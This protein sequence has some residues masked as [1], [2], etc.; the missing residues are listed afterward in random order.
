MNS[1]TTLIPNITSL[2]DSFTF[3]SLILPTA[4]SQD[5]SPGSV[6]FSCLSNE[7]SFDTGRLYL[8][9][10]GDLISDIIT[11]R[12]IP[13][14]LIFD[15]DFD[16][17]YAN[18]EALEI[19]FGHAHWH[20]RYRGDGRS[21]IPEEIV[22]LCEQLKA[23]QRCAGSPQ[24]GIVSCE[25]IDATTGCTCSMR[26]FHIANAADDGK[27]QHIMVLM[28]RIVEKH[29]VDFA[30]AKE[31]YQLSKR[32]VEVLQCVCRGLNNKEIAEEK[33]ISEDTVKD[34]IKKIM[35]NMAVNSRSEIIAALV[36]GDLS[37]L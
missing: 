20:P 10:M 9:V 7:L 26:A 13:G 33:F 5:E 18:K 15:V 3:H 30:K 8:S 27:P 36:N 14:F 23:S 11:K 6:I 12:A 28:E 34:H 2:R 19:I 31:K 35:R 17:L 37:R 1:I 29:E 21:G 4:L 25:M 16:L 22:T 24:G 32:E